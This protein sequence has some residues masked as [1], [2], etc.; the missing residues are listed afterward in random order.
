MLAC[1]VCNNKK[2]DDWP[3]YGKTHGGSIDGKAGYVDPFADNRSDYFEVFPDGSLYP[4]KPPAGYMIRVLLLNRPAMKRLRYRRIQ[5][6]ELLSTLETYFN[7]EIGK[8]E[9]QLSQSPENVVSLKK[10]LVK[11][12]TMQLTLETITKMIELY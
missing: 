8:L 1:P 12:K 9:L 5:L 10:K 11:L 4:L 7:A 3:A 2:A 6:H